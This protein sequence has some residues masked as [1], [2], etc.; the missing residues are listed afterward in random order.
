MSHPIRYAADCIAAAA[1]NRLWRDDA[2]RFEG[3]VV[4]AWAPPRP[5]VRQQPPADETSKFSWRSQIVLS[6][7]SL[8][9]AVSAV[10]VQR[11]AS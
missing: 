5:S 8:V 7:F 4:A 3:V 2:D 1:K 9:M 6:R 10:G 11:F